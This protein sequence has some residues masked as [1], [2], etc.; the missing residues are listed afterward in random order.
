MFTK[1]ENML[2]LKFSMENAERDKVYGTLVN[3]NYI[4]L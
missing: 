4:S 2:Y 3:P 1:L